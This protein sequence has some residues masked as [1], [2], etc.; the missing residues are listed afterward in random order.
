MESLGTPPL[1]I[2]NDVVAIVSFCAHSLDDA[3]EDAA[4][5]ARARSP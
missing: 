4:K 2:V 3:V 5:L 1:P